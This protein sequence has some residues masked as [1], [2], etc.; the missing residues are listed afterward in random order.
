MFTHAIDSCIFCTSL[1]LQK[2]SLA[3]QVKLLKMHCTKT[4]VSTQLYQ[5]LR[6]IW[7]KNNF[8]VKFPSFAFLVIEAHFA[9][10]CVRWFNCQKSLNGRDIRAEQVL[11]SFVILKMLS[12]VS[13]QNCSNGKDWKVLRMSFEVKKQNQICFL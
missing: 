3:N 6:W 2:L 1:H 9:I 7:R 5:T 8:E 4:H 13:L 12:Q 11:W 10:Y